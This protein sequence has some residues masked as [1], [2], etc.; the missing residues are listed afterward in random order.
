M[1][2]RL[3]R[4]LGLFILRALLGVVMIA[5]GWQ[6]WDN[7]GWSGVGKM[8]SGMGIPNAELAGRFTMLFEL[9]GGALLI[10]GVA[11]R[12]MGLVYAAVMAGAIY[13]V[14]GESGFYAQDNGYE[15]VL[16]LGI[17]GLALALLGGGLFGVDGMLNRG[18]LR[19]KEAKQQRAALAAGEA[20]PGAATA[21]YGHDQG[22]DRGADDRDRTPWADQ[23]RGGYDHDRD[24]APQQRVDETPADHGDGGWWGQG[25]PDAT[26]PVSR[27]DRGVDATQPVRPDSDPDATRPVRPTGSDPDATRPV[28][29]RAIDDEADRGGGGSTP[30]GG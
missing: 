4:P 16:T 10:L 18:R 1:I 9:I 15:F 8:F 22:Y 3:T 25:D 6:K 13:Y 21:G 12:L 30:A 27:D 28:P 29:R 20:G 26:R 14:H 19:R 17:I 24:R 7:A 23:D 2:D 5:H 11:V